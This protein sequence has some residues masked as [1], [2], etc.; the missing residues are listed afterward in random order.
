MSTRIEQLWPLFLVGDMAVS[1]A[2]YRDTLGFKVVG[3]AG[4]ERFIF[5]C[6]LQ[7]GGACLMLQ[8][9]DAGDSFIRSRDAFYIVCDDAEAIYE[10]L[11]G[12]GLEIKP[13]SVAYYG[14]KQVAVPE[15]DGREIVFENRTKDLAE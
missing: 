8:Q 1:L 4:S 14:M 13:P 5:W 6:R 9:M 7:R 3:T 10:E 15:P 2:F 11:S 12:K